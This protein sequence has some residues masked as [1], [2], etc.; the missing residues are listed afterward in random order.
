MLTAKDG[1]LE[2]RR[3]STPALNAVLSTPGPTGIE[4]PPGGSDEHVDAPG[5]TA[6]RPASASRVTDV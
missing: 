3:G 5:D 2:R 6:S 1:E 4:L